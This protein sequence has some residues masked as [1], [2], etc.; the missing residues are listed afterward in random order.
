MRRIIKEEGGFE[1]VALMEK[2]LE[3]LPIL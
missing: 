3:K 2:K 1:K